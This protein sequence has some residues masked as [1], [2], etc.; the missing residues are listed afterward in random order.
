MIPAA[1]IS[2]VAPARYEA[3]FLCHDFAR[4]GISAE[5]RNVAPESRRLLAASAP[6]PEV[7]ADHPQS[8]APRGSENG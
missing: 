6:K 1:M 5:M 7:L 3:T 4:R 2:D 8:R